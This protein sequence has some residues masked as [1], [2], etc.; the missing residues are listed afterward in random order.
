MI[1][2]NDDSTRLL[3]STRQALADVDVGPDDAAAGRPC[4]EC[5]DGVS[6]T[7]AKSF[8]GCRCKRE[9]QSKPKK[10]TRDQLPNGTEQYFTV[11]QEKRSCGREWGHVSR[12][13]LNG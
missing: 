11:V 1:P 7:A 4:Q 9:M 12:M 5:Q 8:R 3:T 6:L 2:P 10:R 13:E